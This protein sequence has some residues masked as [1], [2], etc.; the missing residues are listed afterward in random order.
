MPTLRDDAVVLRTQLLGEADRIVT[1]L[2]RE[3]GRLR[4]VGKGVRRTA[5]RF[6]SRLEPGTHVDLELWQGRSD[7]L[8]VQQA[9]T[10]EPY[11]ERLVADYGAWTA[12]AA[13]LEAADRLAGE[14]GD[15]QPR[16]H[17]T[18]VGALAALAGRRHASPL[19]LDAFVLRALRHAGYGVALDACAGCGAPGPHRAFHVAAGGAVCPACRPAGASSPGADV[20]GLLAALRDADWATADASEERVRSAGSGLVAA[21]L[22]HHLERGLRSLPL[23]ERRPPEPVRPGRP[24]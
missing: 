16:L 17:A 5:S 9:V 18:L 1:L 11:G 15:P 19:V 14:D 12:G 23:V 10:L 2:T 22:Q 8:T 6:G 21:C 3:H 13:V 20:V 4:A 24:T 7:L